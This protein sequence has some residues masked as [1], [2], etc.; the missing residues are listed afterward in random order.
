MRC[1]SAKVILS[2]L[3]EGNVTDDTQE[4]YIA[5]NAEPSVLVSS[6]RCFKRVQTL[7]E[8]LTREPIER[9]PIGYLD[10]S[11]LL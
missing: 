3:S 2:S 6:F 7:L 11:Y 1:R 10:S 4:V 5:A 8:Q 9:L